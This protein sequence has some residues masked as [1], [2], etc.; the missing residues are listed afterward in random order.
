MNI[1]HVVWD[2]NGTILNDMEL[3]WSVMH[4]MLDKRGMPNITLQDYYEKLSF[5]ISNYYKACGFDLNPESIKELSV[6]F[7]T[8]FNASWRDCGLQPGVLNVIKKL[9]ELN[10]SQSILSASRI[11]WLQEQADYYNVNKYFTAMSG[12]DD[13]NAEGKEYL[14]DIHKEK[15][16]LKG[17][18]LIYIGDTVHDYHVAQLMGAECILCEYGHQYYAKLAQTG[19]KVAKDTDELFEFIKELL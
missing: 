17:E 15:I 3:A 5:P 10:I 6:E 8:G 2:W 7:V 11:T 1:K 9:D 12:R 18:E 19:C 13:Y 14:A 16:G 4:T